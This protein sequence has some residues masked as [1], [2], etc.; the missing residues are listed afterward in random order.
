MSLFFPR[1][2]KGNL[3][4][5]ASRWSLLRALDELG[6]NIPCHV[7]VAKPADV[8]PLSFVH[9]QKIGLF[10][11]LIL[12][13]ESRRAFNHSSLIIWSVGLDLSDDFSFLKPLLLWISFLYYKIRGKKVFC[14]FQGAGP[15]KSC[16]GK[17]LSRAALSNTSAFIARDTGSYNLVNSLHSKGAIAKGYDAIFLPGLEKDLP[18]PQNM[19]P[20]KAGIRQ[21][22]I[23]FNIR[24]WFHAAPLKIP[25]QFMPVYSRKKSIPAMNMLLDAA[26]MTIRALRDRYDAHIL[27]LSAYQPGIMDWEDDL[28]WLEKLKAMLPLDYQVS[29]ASMDITIPEYFA[30]MASLD[31]SISMRLH[32]SLTALRF[33]VPTININ[34]TLKGRDILTDMGLGDC[35]VELHEFQKNALPLIQK[36]GSI[37][38][39]HQREKNRVDR[40]VTKIIQENQAE[41]IKVLQTMQIVDG[42]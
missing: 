37:L 26:V 27:L 7:A 36:A 22:R 17:N 31:L 28:F 19:L 39:N 13:S 4:D 11:N 9:P 42:I 12:D 5:L 34:Y 38:E 14:L 29:I 40:V 10:H 8:P 15:L 30:T 2:I 33:G 25:Y 6:S 20:W 1:V 32:T 24:Q 16:I 18:L 41:L 23:G 3:G 21:P 35:F